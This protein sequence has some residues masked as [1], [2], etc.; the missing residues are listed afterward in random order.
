MR[1]D[2]ETVKTTI[3][4]AAKQCHIEVTTLIIQMR[5]ILREKWSSC[6][7]GLLL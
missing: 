5:M 7:H 2:L 1:G 4:N 3:S 6:Q